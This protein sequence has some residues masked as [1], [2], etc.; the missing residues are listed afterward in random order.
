MESLGSP[1]TIL[2]LA[3]KMLAN[4]IMKANK[5]LIQKAVFFISF[6]VLTLTGMGQKI[7]YSEPARED[8]RRTNFEIIG[9]LGSNFLVFKNNRS[10]NEI[11]V[12]DN[13]MKE[14]DRVKQ[15]DLD[16]RWINVDFVAYN[17]FAWMI[18]QYQRKNVV[19]CMAVKIDPNGKRASEPIELDT[20]RIG[21]AANNKIY[22]TIFSDDKQHIMVF[23]I[24]SRNSNNFVFTTLLYNSKLERRNKHVMTLAMQERNDYFTDFLLDNEGDLV[25]GKFIK[26]NGGDA[27]TDL[28]MITKKS[29][30]E[31]FEV[32]NVKNDELVLDE[33]KLK[34][35]NTNKRYFF[36]AFYYKQRRGNIEGLYTAVFDKLSHSVSRKSEMAFNED[37]RKLAKGPDAS[38]RMAFDDFYITNIITRKDGGYLL[39][40]ESMYT[41]S[42][43]NAFNRWDNRFW[44]NPWAYNSFDSYYWSPYS[45]Y[46]SPF[47][48]PWNRF[49]NGNGTTRFHAEN[50]MV[51]SFDKEGNMEWNSAIPKTQYDD[52]NDGLISHQ[53]LIAGGELQLFFNLYERR[54]LLL[55]NQSIAPDGK[56]TRHPTLKN[57]DREIN[58]MPRFGKQVSSRSLVMPAM[59]RNSL[60]FAKIEF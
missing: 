35:D 34:V 37:M 11:S 15:T 17:D 43:G 48:S 23:K 49:N 1:C 10:D 51:L 58:F 40:S 2:N 4:Q 45:S 52:D 3:Y 60:L 59:Y 55:N 14:L 28:F 25:F 30:D 38:L 56:I 24:N 32:F 31:R 42:R 20:T 39:I 57:L 21:F 9:K 36:T 41:S 50:I 46:Y 5:R 22:T 13:N 53:V 8:T 16:D 12:Y 47:Y 33:V 26:R 19:Y 44:N 27:I 29:D 54:T 7:T 6:L 18:Y